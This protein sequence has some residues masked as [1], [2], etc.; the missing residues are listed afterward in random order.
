MGE[1]PWIGDSEDCSCTITTAQRGASNTYF[2]KI[3]SALSIPPWDSPLHKL[4]GDLDWGLI[5][6]QPPETRNIHLS[7][8]ASTHSISAEE[9][10]ALFERRIDYFANSSNVDLKIEEYLNFIEATFNPDETSKNNKTFR[11][12]KQKIPQDLTGFLNSIVK[13]SVLR[14]YKFWWASPE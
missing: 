7:L 1:R 8:L 12:R 3:E 14:R 2:P 13:S 11:A 10:I 5:K 6:D 4:I 9:L